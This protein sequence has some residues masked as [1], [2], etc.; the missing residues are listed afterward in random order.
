MDKD[1]PPPHF[2]R[3]W[4]DYRGMTQDQL[5]DKAKIGR[6]AISKIESGKKPLMQNRLPKFAEALGIA[7]PQLYEKPPVGNET[8]GS[9]SLQ[10]RSQHGNPTPKLPVPN[11]LGRHVIDGPFM[12][13]KMDLPILGRAR[14]GADAF[15]IEDG[16]PMVKTYR[17]HLLAGVPDA[18]AVEVWDNSMAP[19]IRHGWMLWVHPGK[20]VKAE[21]LCVIQLTD[22]QAL[23]KEL[24]KRTEKEWVFKQYNPP[25]PLRFLRSAVK[26]VHLVV[27]NSRG[28]L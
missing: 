13:G 7:I 24:V 9:N 23:I 3:E 27:G 1:K 12:T 5:A 15:F 22:G 26:E 8:A 17:P 2:L 20:P 4:R 18:Y 10:K 21:D 28:M 25:E 14:G 11:E 6:A 16:G 19:A